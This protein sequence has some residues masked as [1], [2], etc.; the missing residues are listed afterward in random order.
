VAIPK[1][2]NYLRTYR[3]R[4]GFSQEDLAYLAKVNGKASWCK[5][6]RFIREPSYRTA[7]ACE[8][9][10]GV[11]A[12]QLFAGIDASARTGT[13][14]RMRNLRHRLVARAEGAHYLHR[15]TQKIHWLGLRLGQ[16][17][18]SVPTL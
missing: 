11:P 17:F 4:C 2:P 3:K 7:V 14:R 1:L 8:E 6:E 18:P 15:V 9:A 13:R 5:L 10:F 16:L 12:C